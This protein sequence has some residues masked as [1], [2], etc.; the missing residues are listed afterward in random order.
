MRRQD[1]AEP[2]PP[3]L[4]LLATGRGAAHNT[5][6]LVDGHAG[7]VRSLHELWSM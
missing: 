7:G 4:W 6:K 1:S 5:S 2:V 3:P